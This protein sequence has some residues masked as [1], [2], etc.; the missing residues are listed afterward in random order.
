[1][2]DKPT[3]AATSAAVAARQ[4]L[5]QCAPQSP[6]TNSAARDVYPHLKSSA[7]PE[8]EPPKPKAKP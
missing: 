8:I 1:M 7:R 4:S 3:K 2:A 6:S 5:G